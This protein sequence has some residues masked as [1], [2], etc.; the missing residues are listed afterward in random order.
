MIGLIVFKNHQLHVFLQVIRK[1]LATSRIGWG[2][3]YKGKSMDYQ[4]PARFRD[5]AY[6]QDSPELHRCFNGPCS[7]EA[8]M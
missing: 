8:G 6:G 1:F 7:I 3:R 5:A 4:R 2:A